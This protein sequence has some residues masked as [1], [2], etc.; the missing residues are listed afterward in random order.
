MHRTG[1]RVMALMVLMTS[2][3]VQAETPQV[4]GFARAGVSASDAPTSWHEGGWGR[5]LA[6]EDDASI[7]IEAQFA[8]LWEPSLEWRLFA[9]ALVRGD[10]AGR[11]EHA[12]LVEA[13]AERTMFFGNDQRLRL[14][15]GQFFLPTSR[16]AV[17]PLWQS[18]YT[19]GL[20][21]LNSW[22][23]EE[24]R[25][26]GLDLSWRSPAESAREWELAATGVIG[27]DSSGALLAWRGFAQHDR[28]SVLG[29]VLPLPALDSLSDDGAFG[30][31]RDDGT[32]PFGPDLD[33]R[34][35]YAWRARY[36]DPHRFR[37]LATVSDNRGDRGLHRGEYAWR[38]RYALLGGEWQPGEHWMLA[39]EW[40][41]GDSGMGLR[42]GPHV[43]LDF[44]AAYLL[45]SWAPDDDWRWS[46]RI[47]RYEI[48]DRDAVAEDNSDDGHTLTLSLLHGF[49]GNWRAGL[50]WLH[51]DSVHAASA[52]I[53]QTDDTG[54]DLWRIELRRSF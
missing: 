38:T 17:D 26:I 25:P 33:G 15:A 49:A 40:I 11:G 51:G 21:A 14:R 46:A 48:I 31:Q 53:N 16:E 32:K 19:L 24:A 37:V 13:Y 2:A 43:D 23:A 39:G 6:D 7:D 47:E 45:A 9:Q 50:E 35:G 29:E 12:G 27:N 54:G 42:T 20:S 44:S 36:G 4:F 18:R 28:L 34:T 52:M 41:D 3:A 22:I 10:A 8:L 1:G 30:H 5:Y